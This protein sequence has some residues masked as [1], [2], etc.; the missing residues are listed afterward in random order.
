MVYSRVQLYANLRLMKKFLT[1][2]SWFV[3]AL[4]IVMFESCSSYESYIPYEG[5]IRR[6]SEI[7]L[8]VVQPTGTNPDAQSRGAQ[9][10]GNYEVVRQITLSEDQQKS[11]KDMVLT[12]DLYV[13]ERGKSCL[14]R[15]EYALSFEYNGI[16]DLTVV[17]SN[18]PCSKAYV[19]PKGKGEKLVD[20]PV[21]N[22]LEA[23]LKTIDGKRK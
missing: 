4:C 1:K 15:A 14:H 5:T 21:D 22:V 18:S 3:L 6:A 9:Y 16:P 8:F 2:S 7:K 10:I 12:E 23:L 17:M 20:L 11:I 19:T 13:E